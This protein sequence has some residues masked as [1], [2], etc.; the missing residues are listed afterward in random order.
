MKS[1]TAFICQLL[2]SSLPCWCQTDAKASGSPNDLAPVTEPRA[3]PGFG[4]YLV[5]TL[6]CDN[7]SIHCGI[8]V[9]LRQKSAPPLPELDESKIY[10]AWLISDGDNLPALIKDNFPQLWKQSTR[11]K[12][13][14]GWT[15][16][17]S[18]SVLIPDIVSYYYQS[19]TPDDEFLS[20]ASGVGYPYPVQYGGRY[21]DADRQK[22]CDGFLQ[23]TATYMKRSD[24]TDLWLHNENTSQIF[25]RNS[26][27][28]PFLG[29]LFSDYGK[30]VATY[31][32]ATYPT[33]RGVGVFHG[34]TSCPDFNEAS[35]MGHAA[36]VKQMVDDIH[37]MTPSAGPGFMH[38]FLMNW[39]LDLSTL[40]DVMD[41]LGSNYVAVRPDQL[42]RL[43][44]EHLKREQVW[45]R[46]PSPIA[47]I[48]HDPIELVGRLRNEADGE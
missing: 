15:L 25:S 38:A 5:G 30:R 13:P 6:N 19:A 9:D 33:D 39:F 36:R 8:S 31:A 11:G 14:L 40:E 24:M 27:Q 43:Y 37:A 4:K 32:E 47:I 45:S 35:R 17:P 21:R 12:I 28:I 1:A 16:S 18:A 26:E 48:E 41:Q 29:A 42:G 44:R 20:A 3:F 7:L 23:Q 2:L 46:F 34:V 10:L 22:I